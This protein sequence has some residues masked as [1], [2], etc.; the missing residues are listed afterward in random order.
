MFKAR[1]RRSIVQSCLAHHFQGQ[2]WG[3]Q[4]QGE[5]LNAVDVYGVGP[6]APHSGLLPVL[7][8]SLWIPRPATPSNNK[9]NNTNKC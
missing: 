9:Q 3:S 1:Y 4:V 8:P 6:L 7:R 2:S 5:A